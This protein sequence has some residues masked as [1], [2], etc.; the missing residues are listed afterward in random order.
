MIYYFLETLNK[1]NQVNMYMKRKYRQKSSSS[2][3]MPV[4]YEAIL[5]RPCLFCN[6]SDLQVD[7]LIQI[8]M[9]SNPL[10]FT[11]WVYPLSDK[12]DEE[13]YDYA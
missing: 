3:K 5:L 10:I 9:L 1:V 4:S 7:D 13:H 12:M 2:T 8:D 6:K 11:S